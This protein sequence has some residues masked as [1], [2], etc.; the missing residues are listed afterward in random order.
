MSGRGQASDAGLYKPEGPGKTAST[1]APWASE[2]HG[3]Q[4]RQ[5]D[6][7]RLGAGRESFGPEVIHGGQPIVKRVLF[8][9]QTIL[10]KIMMP[11][12]AKAL[13]RRHGPYDRVA[14]VFG[15]GLAR[16]RIRAQNSLPGG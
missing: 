7:N 10:G 12:H 13:P 3:A 4:K 14:L 6:R 1:T 2:R 11:S 15:H 9:W 16:D 5:D 8:R